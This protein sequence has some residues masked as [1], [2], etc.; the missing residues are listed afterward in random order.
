MRLYHHADLINWNKS[1]NKENFHRG[2]I[3]TKSLPWLTW[4]NWKTNGWFYN[5]ILQKESKTKIYWNNAIFLKWGLLWRSCSFWCFC[6]LTVFFSYKLIVL[7]AF[8]PKVVFF[9]LI[10][11]TLL[12]CVAVND[13]LGA[14]RGVLLVAGNYCC[15]HCYYPIK[16]H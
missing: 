16:Y 1:S 13:K 5:F 3:F 8:I 12:I 2:F 4:F 14:L 7:N 9:G 11:I 15:Y 6:I 10:Q